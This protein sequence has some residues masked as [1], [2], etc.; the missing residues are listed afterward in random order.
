[1]SE[2]IVKVVVPPY[3]KQGLFKRT[4]FTQADM[5][6][7]KA[8]YLAEADA[9]MSLIRRTEQFENSGDIDE[10]AGILF[11]KMLSPFIYWLEDKLV[12]EQ[13]NKRNGNG[14]VEK[15][16]EF[17]KKIDTVPNDIKTKGGE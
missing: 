4:E 13:A 15:A 7:A 17:A 5:V 16:K 12:S 8:E 9:L 11:E 1:M 2:Q 14:N 3:N 10:W 6:K